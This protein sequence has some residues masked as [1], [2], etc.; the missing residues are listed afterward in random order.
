MRPAISRFDA[1]DH[2]MTYLFTDLAAMD[3]F[4]ALCVA[5]RDAGRTPSLL[6]TVERGGLPPRRDGGRTPH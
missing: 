5:L 4:N 1:T 6:P 2:L 3:E